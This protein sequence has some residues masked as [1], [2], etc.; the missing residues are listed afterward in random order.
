MNQEPNA[1]A[2]LSPL[3]P[4]R[5]ETALSRFPVHRLA[6]KGTIDIEIKEQGIHGEVITR[7]EVDY[8]K[9]HGQP[10]PLAY[11]LD[12][13]IVNRRI[14]EAARPIPKVI[15]L[16]SLRDMC[17]ELGVS[18][19]ENVTSIRKALR[20]NAFAGITAKTSYRL[21]DGTTKTLEA[22]FT[23]YSVVFTGEEL[24]DG[25]KA[26]AVYVILNDIYMI[27]INGA[28][29]RPLDY[30]YL[31]QLPPGPQ[32]FYELLSYQMYHTLKWNR[33]RAKLIY[34][35]F[36][37]H[38]PQTRHA[39]W[40][41]VRSQM[42]KL[43]RPHRESGY[44]ARFDSQQ[45]TDKH[46]QPDWI[47][48]YQ[49]GPKAIA[50]FR[51]FTKRGGPALLEIEPLQLPLSVDTGDTSELERELIQRGVTAATAQEL[52]QEH[53]EENIRLKIEHVKYLIEKKP[54]KID[55]EAA[56]LVAAIKQDYTAP[57]GFVSEAERQRRK[58][59]RQAKE[60][61]AAE[62]RRHQREKDARDQDEK[63]MIIDHWASLTPKQQAK[64]QA[65]ADA[66]A[67][68]EQLAKETG[69]LK[70]LGQTI[71]RHQHIRQLLQ[72]QGKLPPAGA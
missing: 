55:D 4:I 40:E 53:S 52:V 6:R 14:E 36:C 9:K 7:W 8:S 61:D 43:H 71:R 56:Y 47:L 64:L 34:S 15:K 10:G 21:A 57:K 39:D 60:R 31:K 11:K 25:R 42:N 12:T 59:E 44:I 45:T 26:D 46:G 13:L 22:D 2:E 38:A 62:A 49:P 19:G 32:R 63:R 30:D 35:E 18:E 28:M 69:P 33:P 66:Q 54:D 37:A 24:P 27:V 16:G 20:Q 68:P 72:D 67:D 23:R 5:V 70:S 1:P 29:T 41:Q 17:R 48:H 51:T 65:D 50:E 3:N 58:E